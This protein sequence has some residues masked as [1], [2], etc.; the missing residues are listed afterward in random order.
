MLFVLTVASVF[1]VGNV[2]WG[3]RWQ[4][5]VALLTILV[6]HESGHY[7]AARLHRVPASLPYFIPLPILSPFGT[8]GAVILMPERIRSR[9]ALFDIG[10][11]GPLAGMLFAI[12]IMIYG[13]S[14]SHLGPMDNGPHIQEGQSL[15]YMGLKA[16][17]FGH[18]G[19]DQDVFIHPIALA[20]WTGFL[21]TFLNML[22]FGQLDGGHVAYALLGDRHNR[23]VRWVMWVP[24]VMVLYNLVKF[25]KPLLPRLLADGYSKLPAGTLTPLTSAVMTWVVLFGLLVL[26]ARFSGSE[27]PEVDDTSLSAGRKLLAVVTLA[28]VVLLF[29]PTPWVTY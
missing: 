10:A 3:S 27:H 15:L 22:P 2:V 26:M 1:F 21:V 8:M 24:A 6:A 14:L 12:P 9:K 16:L 28:L 5:A 11:A 13:L 20:A 18:I 19:P 4:F 29:M 17:V 23:V 25:G 7:I